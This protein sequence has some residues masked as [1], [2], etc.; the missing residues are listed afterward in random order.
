MFF[1]M[2]KKDL[3]RKKTMNIILVIFVLLSAMFASSSM[4]NMISVYGGIDHFFEKA[5]LSDYVMIT[6]V[7][8][9]E[10][11]SGEEIKKASSVKECKKEEII[12]Y[13]AV[14]LFKDGEKYTVFENPGVAISISD[15]KLK[16]F[17][18]NNKAVKSVEKG[19]IYLAGILADP[20]KTTI[21]D[22]IT[23]EFDNV[24]LDLVIDGYIKDAFLG[25]QFIGNPR[26]LMND[27][28]YETLIADEAIK[29]HSTGAIYYINTDD[30]KGLKKDLSEVKNALFSVPKS[31]VRITYMLD[32]ITAGILL[33]V[34]IFLILIAFAMLS[35]TI[36]FTLSEDF[37][38]IGVMKAI[39]LKNRSIRMLYMV[40]YLFISVIGATI[41]YFAGVPF[42]KMMLASVSD[43][44]L[45]ESDNSTLV[46]ILSSLAVVL[47]ILAFCYSCTR[48]I[49][50][51]SPID[52]VHN[53]ETGER[54]HKRSVLSLS[55][56]RLSGDCFMA[57]N[58]VLS[59]PK[60]Y[61]SMIITFT[62]CLL[63]VMMLANTANTLMSDK[64]LFFFGTTKSDVYYSST[65]KIMEVMG[66]R[67]DDAMAKIIEEME[68]ELKEN[69]MPGKVHCE[70]QYKI[71]TTY[72]DTKLLAN[73]QHCPDT[74]AA[75]YG[76]YLEGEIP[77]YENEIAMTPQLL[78]EL[79]AKVGDKVTMNIDGEDKEFI[80]TATQVSM[81]QMGSIGRFH[82]DLKLDASGASSA[83]AFQIDFDDH[84]NEEVI[85]ERIERLKKIFDSDKIYNVTD[86]V[87]VS[88]GSA[89]TIAFAKN[90][91]L[92]I[93]LM[94]AALITILMER[95]FISRETTEIALM[96]AIGFRSGSISAQH[97]LRFLTVSI[98]SYI[99]AAVL[100]IPVT[101]LVSDRI[102]AIMGAIAKIEYEIKPLEV[103]VLYPAIL[104]A[105]AVFFAYITSLYAKTIHADSMGNIE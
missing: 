18:K 95:S 94:I 9:G 102:F 17:D 2:L 73:M 8:N 103:F 74:K 96:K 77:E 80:I 38:E 58:D 15:A 90:M 41:G 28:D 12:Y 46:G 67:S 65:D 49:N 50:K 92:I 7:N 99:V 100:S 62:L 45:L 71:P 72:K 68:T 98:I 64:L 6:I 19:H 52:A 48:S 86:Y 42:G 32:M 29:D 1:R 3:S 83:M 61:M 59:K 5:G 84:P 36:R 14:N 33:I 85:E 104:A 22:S 25:S 76:C 39:G 53:A 27:E 93:S 79:G 43:R 57:V 34:S 47:M 63:L 24:K 82:E 21:G 30:M 60:Q 44:V 55:K 91:V 56:S 31:T 26:M 81:N 4:N 97:T 78:G 51:T 75:D 13:S 69:G 89:Q 70:L 40:K 54:Y 10:D 23:L 101:K 87:D 88:T 105:T 16:Y 35:F 37:R 20:E 11:Q 66:S